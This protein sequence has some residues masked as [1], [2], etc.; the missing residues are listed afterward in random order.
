MLQNIY[1]PRTST[2]F[3]K[4]TNHKHILVFQ[5]VNEALPDNV[6]LHIRRC[7]WHVTVQWLVDTLL[8]KVSKYDIAFHEYVDSFEFYLIETGDM[9]STINEEGI[10]TDQYSFFRNQVVS[11]SSNHEKAITNAIKTI[12]GLHDDPVPATIGNVNSVYLQKT[13]MG[14]NIYVIIDC[15]YLLPHL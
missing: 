12:F 10:P 4:S 13:S 8:S 2:D 5:E 6:D 14:V 3:E 1:K 11:V 9:P 15:I 7:A